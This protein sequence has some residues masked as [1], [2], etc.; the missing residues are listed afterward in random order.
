MILYYIILYYNI[1]YYILYYI[2]LYYIISYYIILYYI[3]YLIIQYNNKKK[4]QDQHTM[5]EQTI[6]ILIKVFRFG[7]PTP[8]LPL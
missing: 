7:L 2:I 1:L 6:R 8:Q 3:L 4:T 5:L